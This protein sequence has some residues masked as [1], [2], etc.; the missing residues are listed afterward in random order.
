MNIGEEIVAAY[1]IYFEKCSAVVQ[2]LPI[3]NTGEIDI[4]GIKGDDVLFCE[5]A[6]HLRTGLRYRQKGGNVGA[7]VSKF[8]RIKEFA[9]EKFKGKKFRY[10][11]FSPLVKKS[12]LRDIEEI[13][14]ELKRKKISLEC[15]LNEDF[16]MKLGELKEIAAAE[17]NEL[18]NP[19]MRMFQ[20]LT[21]KMNNKKRIKND[22]K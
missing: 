12:G 22:Y 6:V 19:A 13:K 15:V 16:Y 4:V 1:L 3:N 18:K 14:S 2:N 7:I 21:K 10:L 9:N 17:K 20:I 5:V 8:E 11:F